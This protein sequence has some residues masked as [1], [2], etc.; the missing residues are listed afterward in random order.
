VG[1]LFES[2]PGETRAKRCREFATEALQRAAES[3][4]HDLRTGYLSMAAG[5]HALALEAEQAIE[6][7]QSAQTAQ[8]NFSRAA[9]SK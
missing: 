9:N 2:L 5:W 4:S 1:Q 8:R 3:A 6:T 7:Q